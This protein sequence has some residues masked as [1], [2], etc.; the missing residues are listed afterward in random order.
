ME[1]SDAPMVIVGNCENITVSWR[2]WSTELDFGNPEIVVKNYEFVNTSN[3][4]V[5]AFCLPCCCVFICSDLKCA[6][7]RVHSGGQFIEFLMTTKQYAPFRRSFPSF[8][9][10]HRRPILDF[11][12]F[13]SSSMA[14]IRMASM[15]P[16]CLASRPKFFS[17]TAR[18]KTAVT[19]SLR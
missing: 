17:E 3:C 15:S 13:E 4:Y 10:T 18:L 19:G 1:L 11:I 6:L 14:S 7:R 12:S 16:E 5:V 9:T 8:S 2:Q